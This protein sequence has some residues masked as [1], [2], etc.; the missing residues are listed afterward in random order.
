MDSAAFIGFRFAFLYF[1]EY[2]VVLKPLSPI[3]CHTVSS[4][5]CHD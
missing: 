1:L 2:L 5:S 3:A 4:M